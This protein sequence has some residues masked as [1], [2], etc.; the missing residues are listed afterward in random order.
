MCAS[1][2]STWPVRARLA[3][4]HDILNR[5][6][7]VSRLAASLEALSPMGVLARGYSLTLK[8]D[9]ITLIRDSNQVKTGELIQT[10]LASGSIASLVEKI[11]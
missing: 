11:V 5:R 10:R 1:G 9:G 7:R 4:E 2:L 3:L 6:H 8:A